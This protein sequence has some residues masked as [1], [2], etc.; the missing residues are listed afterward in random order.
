MVRYLIFLIGIAF[1]ITDVQ[2]QSFTPFNLQISQSSNLTVRIDTIQQS[3]F[4]FKKVLAYTEPKPMNGDSLL[5]ALS[6]KYKTL[7][8][9]DSC[10][11]LKTLSGDKRLCNRITG[12]ARGD[13][14]SE[15]K[16]LKF[17]NEMIVLESS[18]YESWTFHLFNPKT[19]EYIF[20]SSE[21]VFINPNLVCSVYSDGIFELKDIRQKKAF[22]FIVYNWNLDTHYYENQ[23]IYLQFSRGLEKKFL[24]IKLKT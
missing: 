13:G 20:T 18:G 11:V 15:Y 12:N 4:D 1:P 16:V 17:V 10:V 21:P 5:K 3:Q 22:E 14:D 24:R 7:V 23:S 8:V 19:R 2:S 6:K 9:T